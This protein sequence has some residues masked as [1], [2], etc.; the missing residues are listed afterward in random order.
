MAPQKVTPEQWGNL[1]DC[2]LLGGKTHAI[3][4][5]KKFQLNN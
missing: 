4:T 3:G 1:G 2:Q 5:R